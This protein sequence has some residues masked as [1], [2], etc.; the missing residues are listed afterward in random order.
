MQLAMFGATGRT[1]VPLV[2]QALARG[3]IVQAM[4]RSASKAGTLLPTSEES[5]R[6]FTGDLLDGEAVAR[7]VVGADAVINV[8]GPVKGAPKDLQQ[9]LID[10]LLTGMHA[11]EVRRLIT[12]TGAG[13]RIPG[14]H[15]TFA[16]RAIRTALKLA[17]GALLA[18]AVGYVET[19]RVSDLD[20]TVVRVPRLTDDAARGVYRRSSHL[21]SDSSTRIS[22]TDLAT[23]ILDLLE[24]P[25]SIGQAPVV[26]W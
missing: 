9:R 10:H 8:A 16:D 22:R 6:L 19:V 2:H 17:Q 14:D 5:L 12:L 26:S 7:T 25:T 23:A 11:A 1:G 4:V 3:H 18:D 20:W 21:G 13:V 24:D 15:P